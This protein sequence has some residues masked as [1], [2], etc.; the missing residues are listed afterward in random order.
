MEIRL[1]GRRALVTGANTGI[2]RTITLALGALGAKV[3][4]NYLDG[5]DAAQE[6]AERIHAGGG[7]A[8]TVK[9]DLVLPNAVAS[10]FARIDDAWSGL[11]IL[12]NNAGIALNAFSHEP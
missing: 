7:E 4:I 10:M 1:D 5:D 8:L 6:V 2:G 3:A 12:V 11:V 9:A